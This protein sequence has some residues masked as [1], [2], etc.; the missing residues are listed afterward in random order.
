MR[1]QQ[2]TTLRE[3]WA[4]STGNVLPI[5]LIVL[6]L[7]CLLIPVPLDALAAFALAA[8]LLVV[9]M[10]MFGLGTDM[11]MTPIGQA[12]GRSVTKSQK[13][14]LVLATGFAVGV[15]VTIAEP[16]LAVLSG[17][18][19]D[20]PNWTLILCVAFGVGVFLM[21]ALARILYGISLRLLLLI[22]YGM[23]F[24]LSLMTPQGFLAVAFDAG[25]V[26][27]GPMTVPFIL[28]LG[29]GVA[30]MRSD[31][32]AEADSFGLVALSSVGPIMAVMLLGILYHA[33]GGASTSTALIEA[34]D[35]QALFRAFATAIPHYLREVGLAL[36]PVALFFLV[37][38][39]TSLHLK[40][41]A[42]QRILMGLVYT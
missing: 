39:F 36:A 10:G 2:R 3:K 11:A 16:D 30:A 38:Q 8:V 25:G 20:I 34:A 5:A 24:L 18:V 31:S 14:W 26:T 42:L 29:V 13:L 17:Q 1:R 22:S 7:A 23:L 4:E 19:A 28:G 41:R 27:T 21:L 12:V 6:T 15:L 33:E 35:S 9:G 40:G 37:F 32:K